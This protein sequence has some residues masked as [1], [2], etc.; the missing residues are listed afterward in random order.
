M[1]SSDMTE[2]DPQG[3]I[4]DIQRMS[5]ED[6]PGLRT[7]VFFKGCPLACDWCHNPES[8]SPV[9][10]L[11]WQG[12]GCLG[13]GICV[14]TCENKALSL[15]PQ[16]MVINRDLCCGCG[17]CADQC[18]TLSITLLGETWTAQDLVHELVKDRAYFQS[19]QGG[20]TLSGGEATLQHKFALEVLKR[21]QAKGIHTALDTCGM[22]A[23]ATFE[24][25]L[26][27]VDL[28]LFDMKEMDAARHKAFTG[29]SNA[30]ILD[31]LKQLAGLLKKCS[32]DL[33]IR[34]PV[35]PG[36][37]DR[38]DNIKAMAVFIRENLKETISRWELC[39]FNTLGKDKYTRLGKI[40]AH[41]NTPPMEEA[42]MDAL[43]H[44]AL[45]SGLDRA[46]VVHTGATRPTTPITEER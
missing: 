28:L 10:Q 30:R 26:P 16:G 36:A 46:I 31:N 35:I 18:P 9:P 11:V 5:T 38:D 32:T 21:L 34:T 8:I 1:D 12:T 19:S 41:E 3:I 45:E 44:T 20:V 42:R 27:H 13:C 39:A 2:P 24:K 33:W 25:L 22:T 43:V 14:E 7:T 37:T 40:W 15:T 6:G 4:L 29:A 23:M 17:N